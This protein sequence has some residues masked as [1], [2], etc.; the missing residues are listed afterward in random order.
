MVGSKP[1]RRERRKAQTRQALAEH[2]LRLFSERGFEAVTVAEVADAADVAV[3]TLFA[4]FPTKES[5]VF[6]ADDV[7]EQLVRAVRDRPAGTGLLDALREGFLAAEPAPSPELV[8]LVRRTPALALELERTWGRYA[9]ALAGAI[10]ED[11]GRDPDDV[12][13]RALARYVVLVPSITRTSADR[14]EAIAEVFASLRDG[15]GDLDAE[16]AAGSRAERAPAP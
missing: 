6:P 9:D 12:R 5:L 14:R 7:E 16:P 3:S 2:A 1:G 13:V 11:T 4:Y 10:A 8:E 15:W